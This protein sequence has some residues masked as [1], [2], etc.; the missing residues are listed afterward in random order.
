MRKIFLS[1][2][3]LYGFSQMGFGSDNNERPKKRQKREESKPNNNTDGIESLN[4]HNIDT[5]I[6][7]L[8]IKLE[9][10]DLP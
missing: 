10:G 4:I 3:L 2:I 6:E 8:T 7:V 5:Y 1:L 9:P